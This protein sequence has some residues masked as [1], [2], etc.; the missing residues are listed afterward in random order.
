M[1]DPAVGP[2]W[3]VGRSGLLPDRDPASAGRALAAILLVATALSA[4]FTHAVFWQRVG[5]PLAPRAM[6]VGAEYSAA[7]LGILVA[8]EAGHRFAAVRHELEVSPPW[9]LPF[10]LLFG[11]FGAVIR[12]RGHPR[13][14]TALLELAVAGP[15]A[16]TLALLVVVA[17]RALNGPP[18][19]LVSTPAVTLSAPLALRLAGWLFSFEP[20]IDPADPLA[21]AAWTAALVTSMNLLP[22]GQLDGGH[23]LWALAPRWHRTAGWLV[24]IALLAG[25]FWWPGWA[26]WV[27]LLHLLG[28]RAPLAC[29]NSSEV[30]SGRTK[31]LAVATFLVGL[32]LAIP[33]PFR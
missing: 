13:D 26:I 30:P 14:R 25:G 16:G 22:F 33:V 2:R 15:L 19:D 23:A 17:L 29:Q 28:T 11:T 10:P 21:F 1:S 3:G 12:L 8:H 20:S 24:T 32:S 4:A 27:A 7:L 5:T 9:F 31:A 6:W 18:T